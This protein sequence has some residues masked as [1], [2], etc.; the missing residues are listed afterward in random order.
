M[1]KVDHRDLGLKGCH[2]GRSIDMIPESASFKAI[3]L[4]WQE[5]FHV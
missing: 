5:A 1:V 2:D 4:V 3:S